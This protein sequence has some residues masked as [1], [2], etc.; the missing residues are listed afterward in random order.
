MNCNITNDMYY[1]YLDD[2]LDPLTVLILQEHLDGCEACRTNTAQIKE[3]YAALRV[4]ETERVP[5]PSE[6]DGVFDRVWKQC[7]RSNKRFTL[8][9]YIQIQ[10]DVVTTPFSFIQYLP[11]PRLSNDTLGKLGRA[12]ARLLGKGAV[13]ASG[14]LLKQG[15]RIAFSRGAV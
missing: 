5:L 11:R 9:D 7:S 10:R 8:W 4:L 13:K 2:A 6:L 15:Y 12:S 14:Y 1:E 3:L